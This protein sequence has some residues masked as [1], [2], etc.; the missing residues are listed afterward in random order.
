VSRSKKVK[1]L[2]RRPRRI[3]TTDVPKLIEETAP[4][5]EPSRSEPV[6]AR[7]SVTEEPKLERTVEQLKAL[8]PLKE[9]GDA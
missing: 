2:T 4:I 6:E 3:E 9:T 7:T 5:T 1:I 8:S